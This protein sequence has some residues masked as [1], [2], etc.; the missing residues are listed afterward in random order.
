ME[1]RGKT[2][3]AAALLA[4]ALWL[5][6]EPAAAQP[7]GP[8]DDQPEELLLLIAD[9]LGPLFPLGEAECDKFTKGA[10][11]ACQ[12]AVADTASCIGRQLK[13]FAKSAKIACT[14]QGNGQDACEESFEAELAGA[15]ESIAE[16][17]T[18]ASA[19][20]EE[21]FAAAVEGLCLNP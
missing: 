19:I 6:A 2:V 21:D 18:G 10:V 5:G 17:V 3:L 14:S 7:C 1:R 9:Q 8:I 15:A 11:S 4:A 12:K 16:D 13:S 20:C